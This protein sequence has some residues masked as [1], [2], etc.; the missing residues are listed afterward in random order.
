MK[1]T[2]KKPSEAD[3][4]IELRSEEYQEV[5][6]AVPSWI[7]RCGITLVFIILMTLLIGS[8]YFKY[9]D[10][11][12]G[13]IVITTENPPVWLVAQANGKISELNCVDKDTVCQGDILA[14]IENSAHSSDML[15]IKQLL[16]QSRINEPEIPVSVPVELRTKNYELGPVQNAYSLFI[17]TL[18]NYENF[19]SYNTTVH[20]KDALKLQIK[21]HGRYSQ[22]LQTQLKLKEEELQLAKRN[23]EREKQLF[24]RNVISQAEMESAENAFLSIRQSYQQLESLIASDE[25]ESAQL[26]ETLSKLDTQYRKEKNSLH[27]E[28]KTAAN[29]LAATIENWEQ[30][31]RIVSP[32][33][34]YVTFN[35]FWTKNQY[36]KAGDKVFAVVPQHPGKIIGRI[37][38]PTQGTGKIRSGQ[39]V[40]IKARGYPYMEYGTLQGKVERI[41]LL[42]NEN[43]YLVEVVLPQGLTTLTRK[44]LP[45]TGELT[46]DA[47]IITD[48]RSV[49]SR[50]LSPLDFLLKNHIEN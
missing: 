30:T 13:E 45:F 27:S 4:S 43:I 26:T 3:S 50:I 15:R 32:I 48:D 29:E 19:L 42:S 14:V 21:G 47:E 5:L 41:S 34:G 38:T 44:K 39:R 22:I 10:I 11:V 28:L 40:T 2:N 8:F 7:Q 31:Y 1:N 33:E 35:T 49:F 6:S 9:P 12:N 37:Q 36:V 20:E 24:Q 25:I 18:T 17:R 16:A 46:G 23:Y